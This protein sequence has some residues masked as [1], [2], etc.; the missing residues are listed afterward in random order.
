MAGISRYEKIVLWA[1]ACFLLVS[2]G[3]YA[4][5]SRQNQPWQITTLGQESASGTQS[6]QASDLWPESLLPG[7]KIHVNQADEYDLT[8]LPGI[9]AKRAQA[10][11][12][13]REEHGPFETEEDLLDVP[14]IGEVTLRDMREYILLE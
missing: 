6:G 10:I 1:G 7:E 2:L 14:G 13:Y 5:Q 3:L 12:A 9:G 8:R 4:G 11:I